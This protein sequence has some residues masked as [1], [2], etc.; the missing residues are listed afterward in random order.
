MSKLII[1]I[2]NTVCVASQF[3]LLRLSIFRNKQL[4]SVSFILDVGKVK[5]AC[6]QHFL[7]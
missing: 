7:T 4:S 6:L 5:Y 3:Y 1:L 2:K